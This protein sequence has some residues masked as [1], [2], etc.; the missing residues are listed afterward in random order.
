MASSKAWHLKTPDLKRQQ[1]LSE[2]LKISPIIAQILINRGLD[3]PEEVRSFLNPSLKDLPNPFLLPD[4]E[5]GIDRIIRAIQTKETIA[6]YGD[7]DVDGISSTALLSTYFRE[8]G[9]EV[10][11]YIPDRLKEGYGVSTKAME[12]FAEKNIP[13]VITADCGTKSHE[14]VSLAKK[15]GLDVIVTDHH[16]LDSSHPPAFAFINPQRLEKGAAGQELAGVGVAFFLLMAL[17]QKMRLLHLFPSEEPNLKRHLDLVALGTIG[18]LA[19]LTGI[20]RVLVSFGLKELAQ[21]TKPGFI[22]LKEIC[23]LDNAKTIDPSDIGFRIGPRINAG[24]RISKASLGLDLLCTTDLERARKLAKILDQC[25][26]DR[27]SMQEKHVEEALEQVGTKSTRFGLV[28]SSGKWHPG[29]VGLVASK[30]AEKFYRPSIALS[31]EGKVARGSARSIPGIHIVEV[32][33]GCTDLLE[34]FGGHAA[35]AGLTVSL[36]KLN[37]FEERFEIILSQKISETMS[38]PSLIVDCELGLKEIEEKLLDELEFLK[39]FGSKNPEP[40]FVSRQLKLMDARIVG[41]Y[42]LKFRVGQEQTEMEAIAFNMASHHP[43]QTDLGDIVFVPQWNTFQGTK[44]IQ[45]K[46]KDL[47]AGTKKEPLTH[48]VKIGSI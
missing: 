15:L 43:F 42:H 9:I 29:I 32:L 34:Q 45:I 7:Y 8:I 30:L 38:I 26:Q 19:P 37:L 23:R 46:V 5:K 11:P 6:I 22:A 3:A 1:L 40:V 18:D 35:A 12:E 2:A 13:L 27:Q 44:T 21:T 4:M 16:Q 24:G 36:D 47:K 33:E 20:N 48:C 28:V 31:I 39:P 10:V 17:R 41:E 25:N 14:A